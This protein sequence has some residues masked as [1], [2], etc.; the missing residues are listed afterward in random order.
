MRILTVV[1]ARPQFI[2]A[3]VI[4]RAIEQWNSS[5]S[6][7]ITHDLLHTGQH[8]DAAMSQ[9]FFDEL[10]IVEPGTNLEIGG[11]SHGAAIGR[12]LEGTEEYIRKTR[13]DVVLVH[14][15][16]NS[17]IAG[18]L[19]ASRLGLPV[20]HVE[21]GLRSFDKTMPEEQN[22][23]LTDALSTVLCCPTTTAIENLKREGLATSDQTERP[24]LDRPDIILCGDVMLDAVRIFAERARDKTPQLLDQFDLRSSGVVKP[25]IL[26]TIHRAA[27]TD[28]PQRLSSILAALRLTAASTPVLFPVHPRTRAAIERLGADATR[29]IQLTSP[30]SYLEMIGLASQC[31]AVCTDSGGLQKEA[32]FLHKP[33]VTVRDTSEWPETVSAGWNTLTGAESETIQT[34]LATAMRSTSESNTSPFS[35]ES[36][37]TPESFGDGTAGEQIIAHVMQR[38]AS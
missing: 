36:D 13:P 38:L 27:N 23:I 2:K 6:Q 34:A 28:D 14:G 35:R 7:Q 5:Q 1:G 31:A 16:T 26:T 11:V 15:D 37:I 9:V 22:R 8:F 24:S 30:V 4:H 12:M 21:A 32:F 25:F 18:A 3:A 20:I 33:C 17:T 10:G 19:A 29:G